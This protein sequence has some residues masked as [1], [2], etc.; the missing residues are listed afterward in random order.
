MQAPGASP[1]C[2]PRELPIS[3]TLA[4]RPFTC[5]CE[6]RAV[7]E[8]ARTGR[9]QWKVQELQTT[10]VQREAH[11]LIAHALF[12]GQV[13]RN[14]T[15]RR[16]TVRAADPSS[17]NM[18][19]AF[20]NAHHHFRQAALQLVQGHIAAAQREA[21]RALAADAAYQ[22]H[23]RV[24]ARQRTGGVRTGRWQNGET[25]W[26]MLPVPPPGQFGAPPQPPVPTRFRF[27]FLAV[28]GTA[29]APP[30]EGS[31]VATVGSNTVEV[32]NGPDIERQ[33]G[34][35]VGP[36]GWRQLIGLLTRFEGGKPGQAPDPLELIWRSEDGK[37]KLRQ[38]IKTRYPRAVLALEALRRTLVPAPVY[39]GRDLPWSDEQEPSWVQDMLAIRDTNKRNEEP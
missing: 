22:A 31:A 17:A 20:Q 35:P 29:L 12:M 15:E 4:T 11:N 30:A 23:A 5:T 28:W 16:P 34:V 9:G 33:S 8:L 19:E 38:H 21:E 32:L 10:P 27:Q 37:L 18:V 24:V 39:K 25:F 26:L 3:A 1:S 36:D 6:R 7:L 2:Q 14:R 13:E